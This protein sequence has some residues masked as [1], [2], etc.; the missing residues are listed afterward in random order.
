[1]IPFEK[2][3]YIL[4]IKILFFLNLK[5]NFNN[6]KKNINSKPINILCNNINSKF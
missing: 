3:K 1:M 6:Y 4:L 5:K 2:L